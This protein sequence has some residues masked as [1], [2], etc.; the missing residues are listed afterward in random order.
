MKGTKKL[1]SGQPITP[2]DEFL[3]SLNGYTFEY[4]PEVQKELGLDGD[5]KYGVM[6]QD[7]EQTPLGQ[8]FVENTPSG[9]VLD[10]TQGFGAALAALGRL[11]VRV[12]E[13]EDEKAA[14]QTK[15]L[16]SR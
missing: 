14:L 10:T 9:K 5:R 12:R 8:T 16:R 6:A 1:R 4:K 7:V 15:K 11:N 2:E 3:D 13:L